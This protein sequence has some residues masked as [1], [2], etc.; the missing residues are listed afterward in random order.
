[1]L[2]VLL[3][4]VVDFLPLVADLVPLVAPRLLLP[5]VP[6]VLEPPV[7]NTELLSAIPGEFCTCEI[8]FALAWVGPCEFARA[9]VLCVWP[10]LVLPEVSVPEFVPDVVPP[11][12]PLVPCPAVGVSVPVVVPVS[13]VP[14][15]PR[16]EL[17][18][19]APGEF[20]T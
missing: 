11:V 18:F 20:C 8:A 3:L 7:P 13:V 16:T 12:M 14:P 15:L 10:L 19:A 9:V 4:A 2:R 6:V 1:L 17:L 5:V